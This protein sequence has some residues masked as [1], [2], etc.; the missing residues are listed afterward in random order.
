MAGYKVSYKVLRKQGDEIKAVAKLV[1]GYAERVGQISGKLGSDDMLAE[2][3][4]NLGK[5]RTQLGES[6]AV[7][8]TSGDL[9]IK[10]V[11]SYGGA[12]K[13]QVK[14]VD[15]MKAHNRDFYK[16][17]VVVPSAGG[18]AA[19]VAAGAG[20]AGAAGA[21]GVGAGGAGTAGA[22]A[23]AAAPVSSSESE[24]SPVGGYTDNSV[25]ISQTVAGPAA[26]PQPTATVAAAEF[27]GGKMPDGAKLA[28]A[29]AGGAG[30]GAAAVLGGIQM[31]KNQD[32]AKAAEAAISS[33]NDEYDPE[34]EL[35]KA[36]Q[37]V[38]ELE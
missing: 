14:K 31:K 19:G 27:T 32:A 18:G 8:N 12:E 2:A 17:P 23:P 22:A 13:R 15:G 9:L 30:A 35:E 26:D 4:A 1:D 34:A 36:I 6:R 24:P 28:A 33:E 10:S 3:R 37:R 7:L 16:N 5:L 21:A 29:M 38:K 25:N 20:G 11:E